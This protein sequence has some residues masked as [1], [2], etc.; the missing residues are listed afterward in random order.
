[1]CPFGLVISSSSKEILLSLVSIYFAQLAVGDS[2]PHYFVFVSKYPLCIG[3]D[4]GTLTHS[5]P[6]A[7]AGGDCQSQLPSRGKNINKNVAFLR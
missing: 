3:Q 6:L 1:M 7:P 4:G 5:C 2:K